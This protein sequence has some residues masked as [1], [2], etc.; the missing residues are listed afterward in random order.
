MYTR[1]KKILASELM[2]ALEMDEERGRG[3]YLDGILRSREQRLRGRH[4]ADADG[5]RSPSGRPRRDR[6]DRL[7]AAGSGERL[8]AG[9]A[10][11]V[12]RC[13]AAGR[14]SA[15][16]LDA[17][18]AA[19]LSRAVVAVPP[20]RTLRRRRGRRSPPPAGDGRSAR[21]RRGRR[22]PLGVGAR[23]RS[24]PPATPRPSSSTTPRARSSS[25]RSSAPRSPRWRDADAA[26]AAAR[27]TDTVKEAGADG[28]VVRTLDRRA[29]GR[30]RRRRRSGAAVLERALAGRARTCS[31]RPPTTPWLV[32]RA[33][34]RVRGR[35][36]AAART[37]RSPR[38]TTCGS[39]SCCW[40]S[41]RAV[42]ILSR[43]LTDYH[44]HLRPDERGTPPSATSRPPNAERYR[45]TADGARHRRARRRRARPPLRAAL[46]V[47]QH[48]FWR[49]TRSTT[50][51]TTARSCARRPTCGSGSRP[52][53]SPAA[54]TAWPRCS[55]RA[56][57]TSSS[58]RCTSCATPR[59][60]SRASGTVWGARRVGRPGVAALLRDARRGGAQRP[61][62]R[63]RPPRPR[64][65][66]GQ[67]AA[68]CRSATRA[69]TTSRPSRPSR[70][71]GVAIEVS[72]A[73]LRKP[74]G[75]A[76][77]GAGA[78]RDGRRGRLPVALSSDA[79]V[80]DQLGFGY[81]RGGRAARGR[82]ASSEL[83]VFER[84]ERRLE[85]IG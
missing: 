13:S 84:R 10:Q 68:A 82:S 71:A 57:G 81:E 77:P 2:Y 29:C 9:A 51:T 14:W 7:V 1:A 69:A 79:H 15:W 44:V 70:D 39:P 11:G 48:P 3:I 34:G 46:E 31:P 28:V 5:H 17:L 25:R 85:P 73:G 55:R 83:C 18:A 16:S 43:V 24:R 80:P 45:E 54:R 22:D 41:P 26:I 63:H 49:G 56:S 38:R 35:R 23:A 76:L 6:R 74:V 36:V 8:G 62:R 64:E 20:R 72:T 52:T 32:E 58:A 33:G 21:V 4:G 42:G 65:D 78:A 30:S 61:L 75:R 19:G 66:V 53:S 27:V 40:P 59:S 12:R 60:T 50:S 67:R 47:W 37:S